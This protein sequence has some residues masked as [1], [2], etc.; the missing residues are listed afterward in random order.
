MNKHAPVAFMSIEDARRALRASGTDFQIDPAGIMAEFRCTAAEVDVMIRRLHQAGYVDWEE[1]CLGGRWQRSARGQQL[2]IDRMLPRIDREKAR[3][4]IASRKEIVDHINADPDRLHYVDLVIYGSTLDRTRESYGDVDAALRFAKRNLS[5]AE[6]AR[7]KALISPRISS[8]IRSGLVP[9]S[10]WESNQD[11]KEI[12]KLV[13][14][15]ERHFSLMQSDPADLGTP[16]RLVAGFDPVALQPTGSLDGPIVGNV[17]T[18]SPERGNDPAPAPEQTL[19]P[20]RGVFS[21]PAQVLRSGTAG[22]FLQASR[23]AR[24]EADLWRPEIVK[25]RPRPR[26]AVSLAERLA[27]FQHLCPTWKAEVSG[28]R[29]VRDT[30]RWCLE[31]AIPFNRR[32]VG[33]R[34]R[35]WPR[36]VVGFLDVLPEGRFLSVRSTGRDF[37]CTLVGMHGERQVTPLQAAARHAFAYGIGRCL[38]EKGVVRTPAFSMDFE[39]S[40]L[41]SDDTLAVLD[42]SDV[43]ARAMLPAPEE[44]P[45]EDLP[46]PA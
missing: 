40:D 30:A 13:Q 37:E 34:I 5:P 24:V 29:I 21:S 35:R 8:A 2:F 28:A 19:L 36:S 12:R 16:F 10:L 7:I 1:D 32:N 33:C 18:T 44:D 15:T 3:G 6:E 4:I 46:G 20:P 45:E 23:V 9:R 43:S 41:A 25:G 27:G 17:Q 26:K 14:G 38:K 31:N 39:I 42:F 22:F 11:K